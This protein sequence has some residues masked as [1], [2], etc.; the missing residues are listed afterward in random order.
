MSY[1]K[2]LYMTAKCIFPYPIIIFSNYIVTFLVF[3]NLTIN[4]SQKNLEFVWSALL[5]IFTYN[6]GDTIGKFICDY[7]WTFNAH[8][9]MYML[10][11]RAY[12]IIAIP[13]LATAVFDDDVLINNYVYPFLVQL[14]F[15]IT[16]GVVTGK[17]LFIIQAGH[18]SNPS[19]YVQSSTKSMLAFL[20]VL[21]YN[22]VS[23]SELTLPFLSPNFFSQIKCDLLIYF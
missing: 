11:S 16:N 21:L 22:S 20:M 5:F 10:A 17:F 18:S 12:F 4:K 23:Q 15:S 13:L 9:I 1:F 7:R 14:L 19:K 8:S 3:P 2:I 6:V